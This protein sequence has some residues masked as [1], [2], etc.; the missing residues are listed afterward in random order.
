MDRSKDHEV[1]NLLVVEVSASNE[2]RDA[3][4]SQRRVL[5]LA[6]RFSSE[7]HLVLTWAPFNW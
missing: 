4:Y 1:L 5:L 7:V 6:D 2:A 3:L